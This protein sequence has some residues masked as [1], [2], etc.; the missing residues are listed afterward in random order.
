M[1]RVIISPYSKLLLNGKRNPKNYPFWNDVI[2][3]LQ[4]KKIHVIQIGI[5]GEEKLRIL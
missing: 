4:R 2:K 5:K 3:V 1:K